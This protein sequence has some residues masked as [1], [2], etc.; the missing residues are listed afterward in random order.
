M[1]GYVKKS[2]VSSKVRD[3]FGSIKVDK[4]NE[5]YVFKLPKYNKKQEKK[6]LDKVIKKAKKLGI[7]A[8]VFSKD[9]CNEEKEL[10]EK[11]AQE[12]M[13]IH[14]IDGKKV[15][16]YSHLKTFEYILK[17]QNC[18]MKQED[19]YIMFNDDRRTDVEF[20]SEYI[21]GFK[22]VNVITSDI[23]R[24][25]KIQ[26]MLYEREN[27]LISVSNNR[28]KS[29]KK[30]K[31]ILNY[32]LS[33]EELKRYKMNRNAIIVSIQSNIQTGIKGFDGILVNNI[34]VDI[35]DNIIEKYE[36]IKRRE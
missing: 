36:D 25:K 23:E 26:D 32:N 7:N 30:A 10:R 11:F 35:S 28:K 33:E 16:E 20:L 17:L 9:L 8:L 29:L 12:N 5:G 14:I 34:E 15:M 22:T 19:I 21:E 6:I 18:N 27:I 3:V 1:V 4:F 2:Y 31:Y 24:F 13:D